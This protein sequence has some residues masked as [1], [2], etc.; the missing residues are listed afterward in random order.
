[1][2]FGKY[3]N[4]SAITIPDAMQLSKY[5]F[6][7]ISPVPSFTGKWAPQFNQ[8]DD[9]NIVVS[10]HQTNLKKCLFDHKI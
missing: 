3:G 4:F 1:M 5:S 8:N 10:K 2:F 7:V 9:G 6:T